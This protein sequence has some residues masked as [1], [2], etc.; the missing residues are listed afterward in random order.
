MQLGGEGAGEEGDKSG[1]CRERKSVTE[2]GRSSL[3]IQKKYADTELKEEKNVQL[4]EL[5]RTGW[6]WRV[7]ML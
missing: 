3:H 7:D 1:K 5:T 2:Y 4:T 6:G